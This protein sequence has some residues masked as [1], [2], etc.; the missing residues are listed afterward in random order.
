MG[1]YRKS[2]GG[3]LDA[4]MGISRINKISTLCL[5]GF[6]ANAEGS[7]QEMI[8]VILQFLFGV[9]RR[10]DSQGDCI[11]MDCLCCTFFEAQMQTGGITPPIGGIGNCG[12]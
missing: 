6:R 7:G 11:A 1:R 12:G 9:I 2:A 3:Y 8:S 5:I 4:A 10:L